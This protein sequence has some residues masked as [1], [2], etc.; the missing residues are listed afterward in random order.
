MSKIEIKNLYL[1][2]GKEKH[3]AEKM[4]KKGKTKE[5]IL[6]ATGCTIAVKVWG[7]ERNGLTMDSTKRRI[8]PLF[9]GVSER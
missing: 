4:L 1:I 3:K 6:K 7:T 2:F 9:I 8:S 5:E